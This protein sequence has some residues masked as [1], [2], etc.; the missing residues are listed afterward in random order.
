[1]D[2]QGIITYAIAVKKGASDGDLPALMK[3]VANRGGGSHFE[4]T[5]AAELTLALKDAFNDMQAVNSVFASASLPVSVNAQGTFLNQVFMGM[6]RPDEAAKPRWSGNLKQYQFTYNSAT[7]RVDLADALGSPAV[8]PTTGF[9]EPGARSF[10]SA[11][12]P[13]TDFW[14][15]KVWAGEVNVGGAADAPDGQIVEKGGAAQR[16]REQFMT[17]QTTRNMLTP[18]GVAC[19]PSTPPTSRRRI[20]ACRPTPNATRWSTGCAAPTTRAPATRAAPAP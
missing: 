16:L 20:L 9:I 19:V 13:F 11:A 12:T 18:G 15:N 7:Q 2:T 14:K 5:S 1:V 17:S 10:W 6:F 4:A 3:N 8:N